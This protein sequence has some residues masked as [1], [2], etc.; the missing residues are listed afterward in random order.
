MFSLLN[1]S[2]TTRHQLALA[3]FIY[4]DTECVC[5]QCGITINLISL[6]ENITYISNY[7]R[8]LHREKISYLG[9]RCAFLLCESGT[10]IDDLHPLLPSQQEE[11]PQWT[12][13]EQPDFSD[14][15]IRLQTFH[16][17]PLLQQ[18]E[19]TFV[20]PSSMAKH[21]FYY[22]GLVFES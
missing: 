4:R 8:K 9:K 6:D 5:L 13:A 20:T 21:G 14:Y 22:S 1:F 10:N 17:W 3:G 18:E 19:N 16:S 7:F 12:D 2:S 15:T 11:K